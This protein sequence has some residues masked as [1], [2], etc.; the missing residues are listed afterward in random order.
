MKYR[1]RGKMKLQNIT[2]NSLISL[3]KS[4]DVKF[5][6]L[7]I[8]STSVP[9]FSAGKGDKDVLQI[10][11]SNRNIVQEKAKSLRSLEKPT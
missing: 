6:N 7:L 8:K 11:L 5:H 4:P 3:L 10:G 1:I 9:Q 2:W